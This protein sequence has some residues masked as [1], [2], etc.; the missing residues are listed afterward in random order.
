MLSHSGFQE[1]CHTTSDCTLPSIGSL[2]LNLYSASYIPL[3]YFLSGFTYKPRYNAVSRRFMSL[4]P[5]YAAWG[6]LYLLITWGFLVS[7]SIT[8]AADYIIPILGLLYSRLSVFPAESPH[9]QTILPLGA[10]PLWFLTSLFTSYLLFFLILKTPYKKTIILLYALITWVLSF[11]P[12]LLPWSLDTAFAGALFIYAGKRIKERGL[13]ICNQGRT[14]LLLC[15]LL[16][17]YIFLTLYNAPVNM[18]I[19]QYGTHQWI[20]SFLFLL[21]GITGSILLCNFSIILES[22]RIASALARIGRISLT[23][24]CSH[25]LYFRAIE[26][27]IS[28]NLPPFCIITVK[29]IAAICFAFIL[30]NIIIRIK[31]SRQKAIS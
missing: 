26:L 30:K 21:I 27:I 5:H 16:P 12:I 31:N 6:T 23:L 14:W 1:Y 22:T 4:M 25:L 10:S 29:I 7:K 13:F 11:S 18:F 17:I 9:F 3:F 2:F 8:T 28:Q 20:S 15:L 24:L 19:R